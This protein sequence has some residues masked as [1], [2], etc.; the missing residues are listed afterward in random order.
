MMLG[1]KGVTPKRDLDPISPQ[2]ILDESHIKVMRIRSMIM[3]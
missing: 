1:C 3:N 2:S